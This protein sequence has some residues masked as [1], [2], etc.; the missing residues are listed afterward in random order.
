M[1]PRFMED[2]RTKVISQPCK[3]ALIQHER[4]CFLSIARRACEPVCQCGLRDRIVQHVRSELGK[5]GMAAL[6]MGW[7]K[8]DVGSRPQAHSVA[9]GDEFRTQTTLGVHSGGV[10]V[11][12][13]TAVELVVAVHGPPVVQANQHRLAF[14]GN[15]NHLLIE[16]QMGLVAQGWK[17]PPPVDHGA[18]DQGLADAV[19]CS[20]DFGS[21]RHGYTGSFGDMKVCSG[22]LRC[23]FSWSPMNKRLN[24]SARRQT[25]GRNRR[26]YLR[27]LRSR[28]RSATG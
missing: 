25:H 20:A 4:C 28:L 14:A 18:S 1:N 12:R 23:S 27:S 15:F 22:G 9:F 21:F 3:S 7:Q 19:G 10:E 13:P 2:L 6:L 24:G 17:R 11:D 5:E 16:Q 8:D 26:W